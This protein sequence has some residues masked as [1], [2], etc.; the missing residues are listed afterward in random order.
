MCPSSSGGLLVGSSD[1][2]YCMIPFWKRPDTCCCSSPSNQRAPRTSPSSSPSSP[3]CTRIY[4]SLPSIQSSSYLKLDPTLLYSSTQCACHVGVTPSP[5]PSP[6]CYS[7]PPCCPSPHPMVG[8]SACGR[9][10]GWSDRLRLARQ[11]EAPLPQHHAGVPH[12]G[13]GA[14]THSVQVSCVTITQDLG[15]VRTDKSLFNTGVLIKALCTNA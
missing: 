14:S 2:E 3:S 13:A 10:L 1:A 4:P 11:A 9:L 6:S 8:C 15:G 7:W 5:H 12:G